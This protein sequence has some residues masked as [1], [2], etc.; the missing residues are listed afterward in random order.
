M[1]ILKRLVEWVEDEWLR[2]LLWFLFGLVVLPMLL[3]R[4]TSWINLDQFYQGLT[5]GQFDLSML[6]LVLVPYLFY[7]S[8]RMVHTLIVR[9]REH[10]F[11]EEYHG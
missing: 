2:F 6:L 7:S 3:S 5:P 1:K 9:E 11:Y 4:F 8:Y 10:E